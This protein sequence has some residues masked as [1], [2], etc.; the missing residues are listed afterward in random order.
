MR[1]WARFPSQDGLAAVGILILLFCI[2]LSGIRRRDIDTPDSA[3]HL[4]DGYFIRDLIQDHPHIHLRSYGIQYYRQYPAL[5]F[6]FWPPFFSVV[7]GIFSSFGGP[8][9]LTARICILCFGALFGLAFYKILRRR[10]SPLLSFAVTAAAIATPGLAW[11]FN[12]V[13]LELP[14]L[15][16]MCLAT[17]AYY[18]LMDSLDGGHPGT[19]SALL[20]AAA[21]AAVI[22]TKQPAW[23]LYGALF[24]D[25]LTVHRRHL[26]NPQVWITV[27]AT[28]VL[29]LP[30]VIF[31][32]TYGHANLAQSVGSNTKLIMGSYESLPRSSIAAWMY[33]PRLA[34][35]SLSLIVLLAAL[36]ALVLAVIRPR[37][38]RANAL[39]V[40]WF[41]LAYATFSFYDNRQSR[42][43][44]FWWPSW[45]FLA[46]AFFQVVMNRIS[47]R[48]AWVMP[49]LLLTPIPFQMQHA[50]GASYSEFDQERPA[51]SNLFAHG[52]PGNILL[53]GKDMQ[54]FIALIR[55][56]DNT[57]VTHSIRGNKA[58]KDG[59]SIEDVCRMYR[60]GVVLVE[61]P[62]TEPLDSQGALSDLQNSRSFTLLGD[63]T[64][65]R[66]GVP[67]RIVTYRYNG[68]IDPQMAEIPLAAGL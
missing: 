1:L 41:V 8:H 26:Q 38:L 22:Y 44:L 40:A 55:E 9:V 32:F 45:L 66:T 4:M 33:Y 2:S 13:M 5:G 29:C 57:R 52:S 31:T 53:F 27:G 68:D 18:R 67:Y 7:L 24:A 16:M 15:A 56:N 62:K 63:N 48:G 34:T 42:F 6:M 61:L 11:S 65:F 23:F 19:A 60:I 12:E 59:R 35:S 3:M 39:W 17:L 25:F 21:C 43:S 46:A 36:C 28:A 58:L 14:A 30:L 37:F 20:C 49:L 50:W 64:F 10:F 54:V 47:T 51:I